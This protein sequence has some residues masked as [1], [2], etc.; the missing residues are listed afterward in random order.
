MKTSVSKVY[1]TEIE[2]SFQGLEE[3]NRSKIHKVSQRAESNIHNPNLKP[4]I[5]DRERQRLETMTA[6]GSSLV[7]NESREKCLE[8]L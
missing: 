5:R 7:G 1:Y 6:T 3:K 4:R 8:H 2:N